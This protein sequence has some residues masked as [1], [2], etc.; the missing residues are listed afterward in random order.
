[1][2]DPTGPVA[3]EFARTAMQVRRWLKARAEAV[4]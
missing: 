3:L 4:G 1:V 2:A